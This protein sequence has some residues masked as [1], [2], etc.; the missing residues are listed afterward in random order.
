MQY[1]YNNLNYTI[2]LNQNESFRSKN[3]AYLAVFS[4]AEF[5]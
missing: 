3:S 5:M 1:T 2:V 4:G